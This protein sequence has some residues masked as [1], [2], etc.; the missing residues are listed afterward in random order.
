[1]RPRTA[2]S[3]RVIIYV[4]SLELFTANG[5]SRV[6]GRTVSKPPGLSVM[7]SPDDMTQLESVCGCVSVCGGTPRPSSSAVRSANPSSVMSFVFWGQRDGVKDKTSLFSF[8]S[9]PTFM[10]AETWRPVGETRAAS[11]IQLL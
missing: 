7:K 3:L 2:S 11:Y 4:W 1:M 5:P 9:F 8:L 6:A 10:T